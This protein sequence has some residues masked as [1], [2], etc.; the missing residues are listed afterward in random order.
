MSGLIAV[1]PT[2]GKHAQAQAVS[3]QVESGDQLAKFLPRLEL[4][5]A[6]FYDLPGIPVT[7]APK[8][9]PLDRRIQAKIK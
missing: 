6:T 1:T 8:Y 3:P 4:R 2:G 9:E 7:S 5:V